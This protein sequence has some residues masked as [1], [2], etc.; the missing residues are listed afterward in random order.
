[1]Y[2][3]GSERGLGSRSPAADRR[4]GLFRKG[5]A[6][7]G[8]SHLVRMCARGYAAPMHLHPTPRSRSVTPPTGI[9]S[10]TSE[11]KGFPL[12]P[13][14]LNPSRVR[15]SCNAKPYL[16]STSHIWAMSEICNAKPCLRET[17]NTK[18]YL[19]EIFNAKPYLSN[20]YSTPSH[21]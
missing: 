3:A 9:Y 13:P 11:S 1:M 8:G 5:T 14:V 2:G 10:A 12:H 6:R 17:F 7:A 15:N 4:S 20:I 19:S 16:R 21:I 18:L